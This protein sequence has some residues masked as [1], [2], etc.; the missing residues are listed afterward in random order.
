MASSALGA[1]QTP[2]VE[3]VTLWVAQVSLRARRRLECVLGHRGASFPISSGPPGPCGSSHEHDVNKPV[4]F[5][6]RESPPAI[7]IEA[8]GSPEV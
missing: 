2:N 8:E 3:K 7:D 1:P 4:R 5:P 6:P